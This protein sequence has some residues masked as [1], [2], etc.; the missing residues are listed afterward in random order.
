MWKAQASAMEAKEGGLSTASAAAT[1][2]ASDGLHRT[3]GLT[4]SHLLNINEWQIKQMASL[5]YKLGPRNL[6]RA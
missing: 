6:N 1:A 3:G 2:T 4:K 5:N